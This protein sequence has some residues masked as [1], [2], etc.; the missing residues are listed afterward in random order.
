MKKIISLMSFLLLGLIITLLINDVLGY[1][2]GIMFVSPELLYLIILPINLIPLIFIFY[3]TA[4]NK[5][6]NVFVKVYI[7]LSSVLISL[8]FILSSYIHIM[9]GYG[10]QYS[11]IGIM[12]LSI[13]GLLL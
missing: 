1:G 8:G 6:I 7:I 10:L 13:T 3:M 2:I 4:K 12:L 11:F 9:F 5:E